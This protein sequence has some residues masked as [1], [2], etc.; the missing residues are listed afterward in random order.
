MPCSYEV[1]RPVVQA[2][3]GVKHEVGLGHIPW[4]RSFIAEQLNCCLRALAL[5]AP[6]HSMAAARI[7]SSLG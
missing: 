5:L 6:S 3:G 1:I 7:A 4:T 2:A